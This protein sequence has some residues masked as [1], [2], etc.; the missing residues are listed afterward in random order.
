MNLKREMRITLN[1]YGF[2]IKLEGAVM[3]NN[4]KEANEKINA[5]L[6]ELGQIESAQYDLNWPDTSWELE[7]Q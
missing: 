2:V 1:K 4:E 3:A 5:H 7:K 6:D